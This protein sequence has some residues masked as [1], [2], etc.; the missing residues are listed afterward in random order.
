MQENLLALFYMNHSVS[1]YTSHIPG[2]NS[3]LESIQNTYGE[4]LQGVS[5]KE[6]L[7]LLSALAKSLM[8]DSSGDIRDEIAVIAIKAGIELSTSDQEGMIQVL[9]AQVIGI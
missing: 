6:K 9:I 2:D 1:Y 3:F 8:I 4:Q 5:T 7:F